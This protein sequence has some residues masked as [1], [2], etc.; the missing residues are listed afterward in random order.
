ML[1][2]NAQ[3]LLVYAKAYRRNPLDL[4]QEVINQTVQFLD[5]ELCA[6][7]G[8]YYSALDADSEGMEGAFYTWTYRELI[9]I[10]PVSKHREFYEAY[11]ILPNGNWEHERNILF[12]QKPIL[13]AEFA[14]ELKVLSE[15]RAKR[16]RP[17]TDT[18]QIMAWNAML[19]S[20]FVEIG[21]S[22]DDESFI[23]KADNLLQ[24][25]IRQ[26]KKKIFGCIRLPMRPNRSLLFLMI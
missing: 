13:N 6:P 21:Q 15:N 12:K 4:Y 14:F 20:A 7:N 11:H 10:L 17:Q 22:F 3:L 1:Y 24:T 26:F 19:V 23:E 25:V 5:S 8:L 2:D 18:K 9:E 16:I